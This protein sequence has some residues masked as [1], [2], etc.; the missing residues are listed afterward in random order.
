[1]PGTTSVTRQRQRPIRHACR[2][3]RTTLR[4][5]RGAQV[6]RTRHAGAK[7]AYSSLCSIGRKASSRFLGLQKLDAKTSVVGALDLLDRR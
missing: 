5:V 3:F 1:M 7:K 6:A 4:R 2:R